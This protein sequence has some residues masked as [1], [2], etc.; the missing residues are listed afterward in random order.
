MN[1]L[2]CVKQVPDT[3]TV[4][5]RVDTES[6]TI[7][8]E[9]VDAVMSVF[10]G[11]ALEAAARLKDSEPDIKL[12]ALTM[13]AESSKAVLKE[14]LSIAAD[15][16][17]Q[18]CDP[19]FAGSDA[20][21][22]AYILAEAIKV[23]E[24]KEGRFD[25][26]FCGKQSVDGETGLVSAAIAERL[27]MPQVTGCTEAEHIGNC[28]AVKKEIK[29]GFQR[30]NVEMPCVVTFAKPEWEHRYPTIKRKMAANRA[31]IPILSSAD[32]PGL[33]GNKVGL[34]GATAQIL[35]TYEPEKKSGGLRI[36]EET[37]ELSAAKLC[38]MMKNKG[39]I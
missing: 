18:I 21:A 33:D 6:H 8:R 22:T 1:I 30:V 16:A 23:I 14:S 24:E 39:I 32:I 29:G 12:V 15:Q 35:R 26:V 27:N 10:D 28:L 38:A 7:V 31:V 20:K 17:Y 2:I 36:E 11:Y 34:A 9:N 13:G 19:V 3:E 25:A 37:P 4:K 5:V